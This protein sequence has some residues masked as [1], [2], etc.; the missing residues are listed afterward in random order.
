VNLLGHSFSIQGSHEI[1]EDCLLAPVASADG[2]HVFAIADGVG[3]TDLGA[4]A[5]HLAIDAV[6]A[7]ALDV[8]KSFDIKS[9][10]DRARQNVVEEFQ[11]LAEAQSLASTLTVCVVSEAGEVLVGH[12]GDCRLY[13]L[14]DAGLVTRTLDQTEV[15]RLIDEGILS[16]QQAHKYKRKHVL[17]SSISPKQPFE[18]FVASFSVN[19]GDRLLLVS[20]GFYEKVKKREILDVSLVNPSFEMFCE[21]LEQLARSRMPTDDCSVVIAQME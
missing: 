4:V 5:S 21:Q 1:N 17:T 6:R 15:Q 14:A 18:L 8:S 2:E 20:D 16:A 11:R 12:V 13:H 19:S 10:F 7:E 9:V 3:G